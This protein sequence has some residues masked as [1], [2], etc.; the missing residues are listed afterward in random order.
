MT[1]RFPF[2][3]ALPLGLLLASLAL[4]VAGLAGLDEVG[5]RSL[6]AESDPLGPLVGA[7]DI[8]VLKTQSNFLL[9]P[10]LILIG[11][12]LGLGRR[13]RWAAIL[14]YVGSVQFAATLI[15]DLAKPQ[16][17]RLRPSEAMAQQIDDRWFVGANS[18]PSG[19]AAF[20]AG[21]VAPLLVLWPRLGAVLLA[22]P[23]MVVAQGVWSLDH[24]LSDVAASLALALALAIA[25]GRYAR[26]RIDGQSRPLIRP[27]GAASSRSR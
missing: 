19:H 11:L 2:N 10:M 17:G 6:D 23:L 9:G 14:L 16:F 12:I 26:P 21:L 24:Y 27:A 18:F 8:V 25:A 22:V 15:A 3:S 5:A 13:G 7:L 20:Y 4:V 1:Y